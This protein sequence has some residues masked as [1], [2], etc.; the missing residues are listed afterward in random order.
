LEKGYATLTHYKIP[1]PLYQREVIHMPLL[2]QKEGPVFFTLLQMG[3]EGDF[4]N[5]V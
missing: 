4:K 2:W 3:I 1:R 5:G